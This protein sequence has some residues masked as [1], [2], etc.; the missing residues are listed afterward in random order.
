MIQ[1]TRTAGD[2]AL[3]ETSPLAK[4]YRTE[5][6]VRDGEPDAG[7]RYGVRF[8]PIRIPHGGVIAIVGES[9]TGKTT[10][11]NLL[12]GLDEPD[13]SDKRKGGEPPRILL[14]L[15]G[16]RVDVAADPGAFPRER[17][18]FVFQSGFLLRNASAGLNLALPSAQQGRRAE[19]ADLLRRLASLGIP[20]HE[21]DE[22][23][24]KFSGGEAQRVA[25]VR[26]MAHE[27]QLIFADEPTSNVD[28]RNAVAIMRQLRD[29]SHDASRPGRTVLWITH[30][31]RLA[32]AVADAVLVLHANGD[33]PLE[34]VCLPGDPDEDLDRRVDALQ[35]WAYDKQAML[36]DAPPPFQG[37]G[38]VGTPLADGRRRGL[39]GFAVKL[40]AVLKVG[41]SE[42]FS[43]HR[44]QRSEAVR[45][46]VNA[47][48]SVAGAPPHGFGPLRSLFAWAASFGQRSA[49]LALL[50][51]M[52]L[53]SAGL[54][55]LNLVDAH[56]ARSVNDPRTCHV[57]VK[58]SRL[59]DA[60]AGYGSLDVL[61]ARPWADPLSPAGAPRAT[62]AA[63]APDQRASCE[64]GDAAYGRIYARGFSIAVADVDGQCPA[65]ATT[66]VLL[67]TADKQEPIWSRVQLLAGVDPAGGGG[68]GDARGA[69]VTDLPLGDYFDAQRRLLNDE[70]YLAVDQAQKLGF[71][72][73]AEIAGRTL[74]LYD[75]AA[76]WPEPVRL[77]INGV[78]DEVPNWERN[79][80]DGFIPQYTYDAFRM[81]VGRDGALVDRPT[82]IA[83]YFASR[84]A[85]ALADYL[86]FNDYVFVEENLKEIQRLVQ[87]A[88]IFKGIVRAF[89]GLIALLLV[90]LTAMS[91]LNY[92]NAN[93]QS[94]AL[95]KA[96]G[97]SWRFM[98]GILLVEISVGWLL[99]TVLMAAVLVGAHLLIGPVWWQ[100][101]TLSIG[102]DGLAVPFMLAAGAVWGFSAAVSLLLTL[103]WWRQ[104]RYVAQTLKAG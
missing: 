2:E 86:D 70:I 47:A 92:L 9:G 81:A 27:P 6:K 83:L 88:D 16:E 18:G 97:M 64:A 78:V 68:G 71:E 40:G 52:V 58:T 103:W 77:R 80:F 39:A 4:S 57:I 65:Q 98:F 60:R 69:R 101:D 62:E 1:M 46:G 63:P 91:V 82:H 75:S 102:T 94:F 72:E 89:L 76:G 24:W 23:A 29:W 5:E 13:R 10:L 53:G 31:L 11:F 100:I 55:I 87:T 66:S 90:V 42:V 14:T 37:A 41:L 19:R 21:V 22:R 17:I 99:A 28:Y 33:A 35:R 34:P 44:A 3:F 84:D 38:E 104:N 96:F 74:C 20:A 61:G 49:V 15:G 54:A 45:R 67:L 93:A 50:L 12:A 36:A 30:D 56:F 51:I 7:R 48:L 8:G 32:A 95:L 85:D 43:R 26:S 59:A 79:R 25:F 73:P